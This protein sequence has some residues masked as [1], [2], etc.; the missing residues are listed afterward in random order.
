MCVCQWCSLCVGV[1]LLA[2][3]AAVKV[4]FGGFAFYLNVLSRNALILA[5]LYKLFCFTEFV[6]NHQVKKNQLISFC[7]LYITCFPF[8]LV[9]FCF[10]L[11]LK[12]NISN[13]LTI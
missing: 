11:N 13:L 4:P 7:F 3:A 1:Q 10:D 6:I 8:F 5:G 2:P 12:V 9:F